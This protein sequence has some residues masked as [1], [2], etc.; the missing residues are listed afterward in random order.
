MLLTWQKN[1]DINLP[2]FLPPHPPFREV[3]LEFTIL[4]SPVS[5]NK[6]PDIPLVYS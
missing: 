5:K 2:F 6:P 3:D 1:Y 4:V